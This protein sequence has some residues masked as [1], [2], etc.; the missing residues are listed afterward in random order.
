MRSFWEGRCRVR[1]PA[2][3]WGRGPAAV[4]RGPSGPPLVGLGGV[5]SVAGGCS[6]PSITRSTASKAD[7]M[8]SGA[9]RLAD[10]ILFISARA[11]PARAASLKAPSIMGGKAGAAWRWG[12]G[13]PGSAEREG[14]AGTRSIIGKAWDGGV[15]CPLFHVGEG[16]L[17]LPRRGPSPGAGLGPGLG[18]LAGCW[19]Q[20][21]GCPALLS[22]ARGSLG[23]GACLYSSP[24]EGRVELGARTWTFWGDRGP[25][26]AGGTGGAPKGGLI[27]FPRA[28][29]VSAKCLSHLFKFYGAWLVADGPR[30]GEEAGAGSGSL[31]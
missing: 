29:E 18:H 25:G 22:H 21:P 20:T 11:E 4:R 10:L 26:R 12:R 15:L 19:V 8:V 9:A 31:S 7:I 28:A 24:G 6:A 23:R 5:W 17:S 2:L 16:T 30:P 27:S 13:L 3:P 14:P 1:A